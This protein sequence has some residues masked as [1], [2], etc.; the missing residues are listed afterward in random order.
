[1]NVGI[2]PPSL[3]K[4]AVKTGFNL[5]SLTI[6][7][8]LAANRTPHIPQAGGLMWKW[9]LKE[10]AGPAMKSAGTERK[11]YSVESLILGFRIM[12]ANYMK[13][14]GSDLDE[15]APGRLNSCQSINTKARRKVERE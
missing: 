2:L 8:G 11:D 13:R 4:F 7:F 15:T 1:M 3:K 14:I 10:V 12:G 5:Y 6:S 9:Y